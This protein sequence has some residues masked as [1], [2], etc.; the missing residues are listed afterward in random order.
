VASICDLI[1]DSK[2]LFSK[3]AQLCTQHVFSEEKEI[4][5][6]TLL[7][8]TVMGIMKEKIPA[9]AKL[10]D[11]SLQ[12]DQ[13]IRESS[14]GAI[15]VRNLVNYLKDIRRAADVT[16]TGLSSHSALPTTTKTLPPSAPP[17]RTKRPVTSELTLQLKEFVNNLRERKEFRI[18]LTPVS[19]IEALSLFTFLL[20]SPHPSPLYPLRLLIKSLRRNRKSCIS[21]GSQ[22]QSI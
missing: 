16:Q 6:A 2:Y 21:K 1:G 3:F 14:I 18:F 10:R 9:L 8:H 5:W 4:L 17:N 15:V 11:F 13:A 20:P 7:R 22:L 12:I 19:F